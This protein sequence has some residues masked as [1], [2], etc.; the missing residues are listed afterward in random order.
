M[1]QGCSYRITL[2]S[3]LNYFS[4]LILAPSKKGASRG[5]GK[6]IGKCSIPRPQQPA[7]HPTP[8]PPRLPSPQQAP[9]V[10]LTPDAL[11]THNKI[12]ESVDH[13]YRGR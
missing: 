5:K 12:M 10:K 11:R 13:M 2:V 7:P 1:S 9:R 8:C 3:V 4:F 6:G